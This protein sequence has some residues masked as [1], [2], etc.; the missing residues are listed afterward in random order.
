M[1]SVEW[2]AEDCGDKSPIT[3]K[4]QDV[5]DLPATYVEKDGSVDWSVTIPVRLGDVT[6]WTPDM[7]PIWQN[8]IFAL[9]TKS[10]MKLASTNAQE[11]DSNNATHRRNSFPCYVLDSPVYFSGCIESPVGLPIKL[12]LR[13]SSSDDS[14]SALHLE[15]DYANLSLVAGLP[16]KLEIRCP[17][18]NAFDFQTSLSGT[19]T[20]SRDLDS[21]EAKF[22]DKF[23]NDATV[24]GIKACKVRIC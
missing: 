17:D 1:L 5:G 9:D 19:V 20:S 8:G 14:A 18:L 13:S 15:N 23:G 4:V 6:L 3:V 10:A 21:L 11:T 22:K 16:Y 24:K 2:S 12:S 7:T